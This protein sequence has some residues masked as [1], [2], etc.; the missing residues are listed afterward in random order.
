M[1]VII[2][3]GEDEF[4]ISLEINQLR[5]E[6]CHPDWLNFNYTKIPASPEALMAG[7]TSAMTPPWGEGGRLVWLQDNRGECTENQLQSWENCLK[8]LPASNT[9]LLTSKTKPDGRLKSTKLL[10]KYAQFKEYPIIPIWAT[11]Q[12]AQKVQE[13]AV[14]LSINLS[15][16]AVTALVEAVGNDTRLLYSELQ[17]LKLY[18]GTRTVEIED[19]RTLVS[20]NTSSSL[21]L[22]SFILQRNLPAALSC[23]NDLFN[24]NEPPLRIVATLV[25]QF[26]TWL[27]VK[28][29]SQQGASNQLIA[30]EA[31]IGNPNRIYYLKQETQNCRLDLLQNALC[32]LLEL[33]IML[34]SGQDA[35]NS[36]IIQIQKLCNV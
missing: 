4:A 14:L 9:L 26:R 21:K 20:S 10:Q 32:L 36:L 18:V 29:M 1:T 30:K 24:S 28:L 2:L 17:K 35:R 6:I 33:E 25:T 15:P 3:H 19:V 34:K 22:A 23:I 16:Q 7:I 8:N 27:W 11:E 31:E 5:S 13:I 12:L